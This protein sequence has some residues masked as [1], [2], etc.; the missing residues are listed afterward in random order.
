MGILTRTRPPGTAVPQLFDIAEDRVLPE[1]PAAAGGRWKF[2]DT[3]GG[4]SGARIWRG[5]A[6]DRRLCLK[7]HPRGADASRLRTV[8]HW[9]NRARATGLDF[10][11]QV[12]RTRAGQTV[13]EAA[14][15]PWELLSWLPG[16]ADFHDNPS[17]LRLCAAVSALAQLHD[18]WSGLALPA[19]PCPAVTRRQQALTEWD[20]LVK[21]GWRPRFPADDPVRPYAE[22][23]WD[24]LPAAVALATAGL[25]DW[26]TRPVP[27]Q[28]CAG[29]L[30][31]D[32]VLFEGDGV[33]GLIDFGAARVDHVAV[34]LARLLGSLVPDD[35]ARTEVALRDYEAIRP[36]PQP[37]L[38]HLLDRT[39]VVVSAANWLRWLYHDGR[40]YGARSAV[41]TRLAG[42]VERLVRHRTAAWPSGGPEPVQLL[43]PV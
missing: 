42:I 36:I 4:F 41:A 21:G 32:H 34:D 6:G 25:A 40:R 24:L 43:T 20:Q 39:G 29:D 33:T 18:A 28:P 37:Q 19:V 7:A 26:L 23:A 5:K 8:H 14:D 38:V 1:F 31:H 27:V 10:V 15:R 35:A 12:E 13:V 9:M 3:A 2:L 30:W 17:D 22:A 11:P 16:R